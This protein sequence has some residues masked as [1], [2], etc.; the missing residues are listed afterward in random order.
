VDRLIA[1][2]E[3]DVARLAGEPLLPGLYLVAT[4]IGNLGDITLRALTVLARADI[5]YC[6]DTR[7]SARLLQHFSISA[8][9]RPLHDHNEDSERVRVLRDLEAGKRIA[10]ISDAG[11]PLI[12]DPGFKLVRDCA[13][14]GHPV[15]CI[16]G[17]SSVITAVASSGLPTDAF[18]FAGFLPPK[19]AA[20]RSRLAELKAVPGTLIF[21]EAPQRT[22][23]S[24]A[25]MADVLG[26][27]D[28]VMARELTKLHEE[29]A[30]GT[31]EDLAEDV[32]TRDLKG[33]VVLV[34]GPATAAEAT[35]AD[36]SA[37]LELALRSMSLK[38]AAKAVSDALGVAKT[39]VYDI[40]LKLKDRS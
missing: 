11:T 25:D 27:R 13:A 7:H 31:L 5:I 30:R 29:L 3:R 22:G 39:R 15:V 19:Q 9:T 2:V 36:I 12:S 17:P 34:V 23:E 26:G 37:K 32:K 21:F 1:A 40:G 16:P 38:D 8:T 10:L 18:F 20:R 28:A 35:D 4:P 33:E 6:E 24:L 14:A